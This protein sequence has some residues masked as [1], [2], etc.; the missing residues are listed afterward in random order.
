MAWIGAA[1]GGAISLFNG[2]N[3]ADAAQSA[4]QTQAA[5]QGQ[6]AAIQKQMFDTINEQQAPWRQAG[7]MSLQEL[8]FP[9]GLNSYFTHKFTKDDLTNGLSPNY[10]FMLEQGLGA[11]KNQMNAQG[12]LVSGNLLKGVNDYAQNYASNAYQQAFQNYAAQQTNIFNRL[13]NIAGLGQ[14]ANQV[15][16]NAATQAGQGIGSALGNAAT[17]QAGGTIGAANATSGG[18]GSAA[19]WF[20]LPSFL[21]GGGGATD[22][23]W[24]NW[25]SLPLAGGSSIPIA[26]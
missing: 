7:Q 17:A 22:T 9:F 21:K 16:A 19:S 26:E 25:E 20:S 15:T 2:M 24:D 18:L 13:S 1:I 23:S 6:S 4:A 12:G 3:Q 11:L 14:T 10:D 8:G 5:G